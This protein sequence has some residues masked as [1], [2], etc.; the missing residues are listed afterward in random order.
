MCRFKYSN[1][2]SR[3]CLGTI[4]FPN[5]RLGPELPPKL[6]ELASLQRTVTGWLEP[7]LVAGPCKWAANIGPDILTTLML[8]FAETDGRVKVE[9]PVPNSRSVVRIRGS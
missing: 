1:P 6:H 8:M 4:A 5:E 3:N 9:L 2:L 7:P